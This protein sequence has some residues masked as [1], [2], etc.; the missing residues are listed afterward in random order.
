MTQQILPQSTTIR[1]AANIRRVCFYGGPGA[2]KSAMAWWLAAELKAKSWSV[3]TIVE[4][5]KEWAYRGQPVTEFDQ[6]YVFH[7]Q[8]RQEDGFLRHGVDTVVTDAPLYLMLAYARRSWAWM[9]KPLLAFAKRFEE[10]YP[11]VHIVLHR[12]SNYVQ[13]GRYESPEDAQAMDELVHATLEENDVGY[14]SARYDER[15]R[16]LDMVLKFSP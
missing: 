16:V 10:V 12:P 14:F 7:N 8:V 11:A 6:A 9:Y 13:S 2:G 15:E 4:T 5:C 1:A 3:E